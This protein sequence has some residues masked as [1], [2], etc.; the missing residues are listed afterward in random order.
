MRR[1]YQFP[2]LL[3]CLTMIVVSAASAQEKSGSAGARFGVGTDINGGL[4]YGGQLDYTLNQG[5]NALE[6]GFSACGGKF[7]EDSD[8]GFN[9]YH[10]ETTILVFG[11]IANYLFRYSLDTGG[12][13]FLTGA[14]FGAF[15]VKWEE[16][17]E[18]DS[19]LG[20]LLPGG[21]SMQSEE[22]TTGGFIINFGIGHRFS[23]KFDL[24][25]QIPT[26]F[27]SGGVERE[28]K[29]VPTITITA[30]FKFG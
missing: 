26:F 8:N 22:E 7:E 14:G 1:S 2:M 15:A 20:T 5:S 29:V 6:L 27:I 10:E 12:P 25:A 30:G 23:E 19:T 3:A 18:T 24:R 4:A 21:G 9:E 17:S 11:A 28:A 16:S 13:Y